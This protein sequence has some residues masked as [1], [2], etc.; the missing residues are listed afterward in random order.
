MSLNKLKFIS[1]LLILALTNQL[2]AK[3]IDETLSLGSVNIHISHWSDTDPG[4]VKPTIILLSGPTD[5]WNSDSA[6]FARLAPKLTK[7]HRVMAI[8]RVGQ[9]LDT[10]NA[11]VGYEQFSIHLDKVIK[12]YQLKDVQIIAFASSNLALNHYFDKQAKHPIKS[13]IMI[14][15]D[16]LTPFSIQRYKKD[17]FPF[18][19]NLKG[20]LEYINEG[21]YGKRA[22]E[23]NTNDMKLLQQLSNNDKDTD[24]NY[25][26]FMF[27]NRLKINNLKNVFR[28]I[29]H[30]DHDLDTAYQ[31]GFPN[32]IPLTI[33]DTNFE[34]QYLNQT[35]DAEVRKGLNLW[36]LDAK[37]YYQKLTKAS[38]NGRYIPLQTKEHL[39][40]F[41]DPDFLVK[42]IDIELEDNK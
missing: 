7:T 31:I 22:E 4:S 6:W 40:P 41:S 33:I 23:K 1:I 10:I 8:D 37:D 16:V 34:Q 17:A 27:S 29:A 42:L 2:H 11:Q 20:Y 19:Q 32:N 26:K 25:V 35:K 24:W 13:V 5:N 18:K 38:I 30:Y 14:D 15:P 9:V 39:I 12:H 36:R 28:E 21:K 3:R